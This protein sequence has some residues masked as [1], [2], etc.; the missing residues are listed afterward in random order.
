MNDLGVAQRQVDETFTSLLS[1]KIPPP[2]AVTDA[3][4]GELQN[5]EGKRQTES[6]IERDRER[7]RRNDLVWHEFSVEI[8]DG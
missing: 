6:L 7:Q 4:T 2:A 8:T 1:V 5:R 3:V